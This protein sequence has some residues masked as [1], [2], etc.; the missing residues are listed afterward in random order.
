[1][2]ELDPFIMFAEGDDGRGGTIVRETTKHVNDMCST[3]SKLFTSSSNTNALHEAI[4]YR[5]FVES[6]GEH[7]IGKQS[8]T[9]LGLVMRSILLQYGNNNDAL[10]TRKQVRDLNQRVLDFC[11]AK[12]ISEVDGYVRYRVDASTLHTPL[13][14]AQ[15]SSTKGTGERSLSY[16]ASRFL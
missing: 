13:E 12:V 14:N 7:T 11:V 4:R 1:M 6:G 9:E 5:V 16:G 8:D 3:V 2:E 10:D 15:A